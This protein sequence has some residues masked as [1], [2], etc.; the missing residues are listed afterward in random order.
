MREKEAVD[1]DTAREHRLIERASA[2]HVA[3]LEKH[4]IRFD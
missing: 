4:G 2:A 1:R 3:A